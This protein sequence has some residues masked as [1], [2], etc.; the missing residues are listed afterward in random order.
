MGVAQSDIATKLLSFT[1]PFALR[2]RGV[3]TKIVAAEAKRR[4][5]PTLLRTLA[6]AHHWTRALRT[7]RGITEIAKAEGHSES[8]IRTRAQLAFLSPRL[9]QAILEGTQPAELTVKSIIRQPV[10]LDWD[11]QDRLYGIPPG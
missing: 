4:P 2:R 6:K 5:D 7:G 1:V 3:E 9:Q 8:F 11:A 10:P